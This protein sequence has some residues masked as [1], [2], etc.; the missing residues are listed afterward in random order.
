[1]KKMIAENKFIEHAE[2]HGKYYGESIS[3]YLFFTTTLTMQS[4]HCDSSHTFLAH[5][6]ALPPPPPSPLRRHVIRLGGLGA[7]DGQDLYS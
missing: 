2:V 3:F 1:M 5:P 6:L 4:T 7:E